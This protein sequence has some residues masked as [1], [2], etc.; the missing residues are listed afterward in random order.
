MERFICIHAHFYQPPR[1]NPWLE[2]VERQE[3]AYPYHDWNERITA[4]CYAPNGA[5]RILD[6]QDRILEI[7]NNYSRI[8]FN[9]GPTL[10]SWMKENRPETYRCI[11]ESDMESRRRFSGHGS[12]LAQG[13]NHM[14]LPLANSR[15]KYTQMLWGIRDFERRFG[16]FPEGIWLPETAVDLETLDILAELGIKFTILAPRQAGR[17]RKI[18]GRSWKDISGGR[19]DPSR[20]YL[21]KLPSGRK[22]NLFFYDGPISQAVAFEKLLNRGEQ[23]AARLKSGFSDGRDCPQLVHIATDGETYGHHHRYGEMALAYALHHIESNGIAKLTNYGEFLERFPPTHEVQIVENT[24]WSCVHGVERWR[25]NCGCNTGRPDWN[26]EWRKPLRDALDYLRD[27]VASLFQ[28][29]A[30]ELLRDP[31][32]ARN[33]Y[34]DVVLDRSPES[35]WIF[36][37]KHS[38]RQL[39]A[40]ETV[41]A[42]KLLEMQRHAMLMYTSCGWFFDEISGIETV[43]VMQYAGRVLQ[44]ASEA[45]GENLEP[46]F[47]NWLAGARSNIP[48]LENGAKIYD[49]LV[50]PV[51][52]DLCKVGAHF[53]ISSIFEGSTNTPKFCYEIR[54]EDYQPMES[55]SVKLA[56][57]RIEVISQTT[58]DS[59]ELVFGVIHLGDQTLHA[60]VRDFIDVA[61]YSELTGVVADAFSRGD[62]PELLHFLDQHLGGMRYSLMSLFRDEQKRILDLILGQMLQETE[63]NYRE[64]YQ[65]HGPLLG[66]LRDMNQTVP[67]VLRITAEFVLNNDLKHTFETD[68]IDAL[69]LS[70]LMELVKREGVRLEE[71]GLNFAA[72]NALTRLMRCLQEDPNSMERLENANTLVTLLQ[73]FPFQVNYW[74]AQNIF[75]SLLQHHFPAHAGIEDAAARAWRERFLA[76]G[77]KLRVSVPA[78]DM[79]TELQIAS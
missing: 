55:G 38:P 49:L 6:N 50:R 22:I 68:P 72:S 66:F 1:E 27:S 63:A 58:L 44:L 69:R 65:R 48:E 19:I 40:E 10:L 77:E 7:V 36:F 62:V 26:Q 67:D 79:K 74:E 47:V 12:A 43:Q 78:E 17:I 41:A 8:S 25:S 56:V 16:R 61:D 51:F 52:V 24:S 29:H 46:Q 60:G 54:T 2:I 9:F 3:S 57:G 30:G 70:M 37:E 21:A 76:L 11:L 23:F 53:A 35:L 14:I 13:Y 5:S 4:E 73:M 18:G 42:L 75:Y 45:A 31:W 71:A 64:I 34:I 59:R 39:K 15:D 32:A 20:A 33:D 28:R